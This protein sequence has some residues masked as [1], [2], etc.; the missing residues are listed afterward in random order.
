[1]CFAVITLKSLRIHPPQTVVQKV[2]KSQSM[3]CLD[4]INCKLE[5]LSV[6]TH[7]VIRLTETCRSDRVPCEWLAHSSGDAIFLSSVV[8]LVKNICTANTPP[9]HVDEYA[10]NL[11]QKAS[12]P[13]KIG[14]YFVK[15]YFPWMKWAELMHEWSHRG[16]YWDLK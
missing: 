14:I 11:Y 9:V 1:M 15:K 6:I 4:S 16:K 13:P 8:N 5:A 12:P 2:I 7:L 10:I 3:C